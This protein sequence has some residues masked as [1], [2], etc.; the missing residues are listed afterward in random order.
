M[1]VPVSELRIK[2]LEGVRK[3]GYEDDDAKVITDVLMYAQLRG[4]NQGITKIATGGVP[5]AQDVEPYKVVKENKCA[6]MVSGG[7]AMVA[8][9]RAAKLAS[10]LAGEHGVGIVASNHTFTSS[11]AIGYFS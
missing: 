11:G 5:T 8:C 2:V 10:E 9:V 6:V 7:H 1:E 3:L 4:N